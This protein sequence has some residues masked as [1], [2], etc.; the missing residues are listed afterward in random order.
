MHKVQPMK[1]TCE[2]IYSDTPKVV[3][4]ELEQML[5]EC[6]DLFV[7]KLPKGKAPRRAIKFEIKR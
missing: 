1:E 2:K 6:E 4:V 3:R 7:E 5:R